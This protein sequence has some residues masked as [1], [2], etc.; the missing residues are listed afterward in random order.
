MAGLLN[1]LK[2][3]AKA[4]IKGL[5]RQTLHLKPLLPLTDTQWAEIGLFK[6]LVQRDMA[7][8]YQGSI[9]GNLWP[10]LNQLAQLLIY[11]YVFSIVL[12]VKLSLRGMPEENPLVFGLWLFAG[13]LPWLAFS[14][15]LVTA[16][17]SVTNQPNLVKKVVFP[18]T[19]LPLVPIATNFL[20][21]TFGLVLLVIFVAAVKGS[22]SSTLLLL[23]LVWLPQLLLTSGMGFLTASLSVFIRDV[24]QTLGV[25][26]NLWFYATP[27]IYPTEMI[28]DPFG[29]W[30][31]WFNPLAAIAEMYRDVILTGGVTHW[32]EWFVSLVV[33]AAVFLGGF[34]CYRKLRPAFADVL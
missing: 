25:F 2:S 21:S 19:L 4:C 32:G 26:L 16:T 22:V 5:W 12:R 18:I 28:P 30:V 20:D 7:A 27:I 9:L 10:V 33:S 11:T 29:Q 34:W 8:R 23:P 3:S 15:G 6:A 24:P 17:V 1:P 13:L 14:S 31:L